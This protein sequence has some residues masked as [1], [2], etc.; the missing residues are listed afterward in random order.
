MAAELETYITN[1]IRWA[2]GHLGATD[3]AGRC[4]SFVE[5]AYEESNHVEIFGG[6]SAKAV[7]QNRRS[8]Y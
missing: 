4:L 1:A 6:S 7:S 3:Y 8:C 2:Q 5:D